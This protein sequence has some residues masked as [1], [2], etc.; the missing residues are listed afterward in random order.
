MHRD[1]FPLIA[2]KQLRYNRRDIQID[3]QFEAVGP[4]DADI[5]VKAK[6]ARRPVGGEVVEIEPRDVVSVEHHA[7]ELGGKPPAP[8]KKGGRPSKKTSAAQS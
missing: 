3:E 6:L 1:P 4:A 7:T 5:L 8:K 2:A